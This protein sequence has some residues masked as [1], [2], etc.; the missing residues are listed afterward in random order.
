MIDAQPNHLPM[1]TQPPIPRSLWI[2]L[3]I[4]TLILA[5][6]AGVRHQ[7]FQSTAWDL[8]IFDQAIYLISQGK[9]PISSY[10]G[11][12]ILGDHAALILYLVA[13]FYKIFASVYWLFLIQAF[14]LTAAIIPLYLIAQLKGLNTSQSLT[15]CWS[16]LLYP[17]IFNVNLF[18]FHPDV[19]VPVAL[20]W[21]VW[22][23]LR[24]RWVVY[25]LALVVVLSCKEIFALLVVFFGLWLLTLPKQRPF[26]L[27][28][29]ALGTGWFIISTR[30]L[31]PVF[32][33]NTA[34]IS[35]HVS[36]FSYLGNSYSE[37]LIN[38]VQKP[39]LFLGG[40]FNGQNIGYL[41][42]LL[43][44]VVWG[45]RFRHLTPLI[46]I[47]P[48]LGINLLSQESLQKDLLHQYSLPIVPFLFLICI[49]TWATQKTWI[50]PQKW[51]LLWSAIVFLAL[52][53]YGYF[54]SKYLSHLDTRSATITALAKIPPDAGVLTTPF[55]APHLS[56]RP[57]IQLV[58]KDFNVETLPTFQAILL[59]QRTPGL[60]LVP[61]DI[62]TLRNT[63]E[64]RP[65][66]TLIFAQDDIY[67]YQQRPVNTVPPQ[68]P[69]N[70]RP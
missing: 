42:L 30:W 64:I 51:L 15:I 12:H 40:I 44:P 45:L 27:V 2:G 58:Q 61:E 5:I 23:A 19:F 35:R 54:G 38:L 53:K 34:N 60:E 41:A 66:F 47:L 50:K 24:S 29:I 16:Y 68:D 57:H 1:T 20:L 65:E 52:A 31:I 32:S 14:A 9:T 25:L 46:A 6:A 17:L 48:I 59:N 36:R 22:A 49:D 13:I 4:G 21:A 33:D 67:L 26:G 70:P 39:Q 28:A 69:V 43:L 11:I 55:I 56:H 63:L 37:M 62:Q 10:L 7:L 8:G 18:D 3:G